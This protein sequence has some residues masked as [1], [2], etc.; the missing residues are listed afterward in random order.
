MTLTTTDNEAI[1]GFFGLSYSNYLVLPRTLLQSMPGDWQVGFV[2]LLHELNAAFRAVEVPDAYK[3]EPAV[4]REVG[5]LSDDE[6]RRA[7]ITRTDNPDYNDEDL[8][9][10]EQPYFYYAA[11]G[12]ALGSY[13]TV[14]VPTANDP[15]PH[16]NRGRTRIQPD[17]AAGA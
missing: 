5:D 17:L 9:S 6:L 4:E 16:Y 15:V 12:Q 10:N 14:L 3:V 1:H 8:A 7:A 2:G 11:D 13:E